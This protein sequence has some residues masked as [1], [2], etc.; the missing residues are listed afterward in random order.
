ME[1]FYGAEAMTLACWP[2]LR[3]ANGS[4]THNNTLQHTATHTTYATPTAPTHRHTSGGRTS[5]KCLMSNTS[6]SHL[7]CACWA[8]PMSLM[9]A[10]TGTGAL[11][12]L[13]ALIGLIPTFLSSLGFDWADSRSPVKSVQRSSRL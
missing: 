13:R 8:G 4:N 2:N 12:G 9:P 3:N 1:L 5:T 11:I 10:C 7:I 6:L